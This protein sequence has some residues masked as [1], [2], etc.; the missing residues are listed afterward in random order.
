[1]E[2]ENYR[3]LVFDWDGTLMD[4]ADCIVACVQETID[5][6]GLPKREPQEIRSIIGLSLAESVETLYPDEDPAVYRQVIDG[7]R[8]RW[9]GR[10]PAYYPPFPGAEEALATLQEAGYLLAVATGKSRRG[11]DK[12]MASS[13]FGH[14]FDSTRCADEAP[15]KPHPSML[16]QL[17]NELE[18][19][20][21]A[22]LVIGD[23]DFDLLMAR[24]AG[25]TAVA[26]TYGAH[27]RERLEAATPLAFFDDLRQ[28]P[29]WL[30]GARRN[31]HEH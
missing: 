17:M 5:E 25:A 14:F 16:E 10:E 21:E 19:A 22:T 2:L 18:T 23:T 28:L 12:S 3:L 8:Q 26:V 7:Y 20:P 29:S 24:N 27:P 30:E 4:S 13:G 11:L 31:N 1:M 6:L 15:S 9:L